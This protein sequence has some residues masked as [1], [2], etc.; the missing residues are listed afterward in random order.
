MPTITVNA[1]P[2]SF[3]DPLTVADLLRVL[4]KDPAKL[5]V[6]VN[7]DVVPRA[8]HPKR[9][10]R[11]GDAVEIV[12]LVGGG[13]EPNPPTPFPKREGGEV[14]CSPPRFGEGPGEGFR[15]ST[16]ASVSA[17]FAATSPSSWLVSVA[18]MSRGAMPNS[19]GLKSTGD[20]N[21][22]RRAYVM[23]GDFGSASK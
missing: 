22:P 1:E 21:P 23:S 2:R 12:T 8:E 11:D 17:C 5:A 9:P 13:S 4:A 14:S 16:P 18:S 10:L 6:E 7:R 20:R 15:N 19:S 3:P